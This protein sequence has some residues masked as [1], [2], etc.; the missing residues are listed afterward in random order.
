MDLFHIMISYNDKRFACFV[1]YEIMLK[2]L[3]LAIKK[4]KHNLEAFS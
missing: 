1:L 3:S 4:K 2:K